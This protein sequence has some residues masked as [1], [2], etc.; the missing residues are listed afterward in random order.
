MRVGNLS[1]RL[2]L[3]I[4]Q[5]A[6]DIERASSGRF[7]PDPQA[8]YDRWEE[9]TQWAAGHRNAGNTTSFSLADLGAPAPRPRQV[10]AAGLNYRSHGAEAG[11]DVPEFPMVFSKW[12]SSFTGPAGDI[13]LPGDTVDWE[14]ELVAV[15]GKRARNVQAARGWDYIAGLTAGQDISERTVQMQGG[16]IPQTGLGKSFPGFSPSGPWL[17]TLD[18][19]TDP[20]DLE[21]GCTVNGQEMQKARTSDL[22]FSV[23]ALVA[24]LSAIV[25]LEPGDVIYTGTPGGVGAVRKPPVYLAAGDELV[26]TVEG[27]G[28]MR[29]RFVAA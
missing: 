19:F 23:P 6:V 14:A 29:H 5:G 9:F 21:L 17:V 4:G 20:G 26:T 12:P 25:T 7:G 27:I 10:F 16:P 18:E 2:T 3:F 11:V 1:G 22:V 8:V 15:V 24:E 13:V 28:E